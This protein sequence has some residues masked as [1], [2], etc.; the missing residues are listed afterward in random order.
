MRVLLE[1][2]SFIREILYIMDVE[3]FELIGKAQAISKACCLDTSVI[4][5]VLRMP[6]SKAESGS[7][8]KDRALRQKRIASQR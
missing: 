2:I 5:K 4:D 8:E 1:K 3:A 7:T 6:Q